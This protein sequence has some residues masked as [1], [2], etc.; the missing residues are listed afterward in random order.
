MKTRSIVPGPTPARHLLAYRTLGDH[1]GLVMGRYTPT[2]ADLCGTTRP[3]WRSSPLFLRLP[4][5]SIGLSEF[6]LILY[7]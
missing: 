3:A 7:R 2:R 5:L 4:V 1:Y 6:D